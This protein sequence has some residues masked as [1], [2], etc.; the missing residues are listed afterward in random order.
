RER[1][2]A[3]AQQ[4]SNR[5]REIGAVLPMSEP[6]HDADRVTVN[7]ADQA[8]LAFSGAT[9]VRATLPYVESDGG[10]VEHETALTVEAGPAAVGRSTRWPAPPPRRPKRRRWRAAASTF[11]TAAI[12]GAVAVILWQ[13]AHDQLKVTAVTVAPAQLPARQCNVTVNV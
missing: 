5:I 1:R 8:Q 6:V 9:L 13:R 2:P 11:V 7:A 4:V 12:L 10:R 3:T